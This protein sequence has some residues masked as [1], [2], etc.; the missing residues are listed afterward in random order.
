MLRSDGPTDS[1]LNY[2]KEW[3]ERVNRGRFFEISDEAYC[4]FVAVEVCMRGKL[5]NHLEKSTF[6]AKDTQEGKAASW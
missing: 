4:F 2:T 6:A 1:L 5:I 3:I